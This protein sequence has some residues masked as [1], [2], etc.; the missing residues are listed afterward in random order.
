VA[1]PDQLGFTQNVYGAKVGATAVQ[2]SGGLSTQIGNNGTIYAN[3]G[4]DIRNG[5]NA[6]SG[7]IGYR[8][9]F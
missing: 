9:S 4:A 7:T 2:I 6:V 1:L 3:A 5:E 8:Y